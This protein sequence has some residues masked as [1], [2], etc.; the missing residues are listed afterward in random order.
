MI[1]RIQEGHRPT[2]TS[3]VLGA[4]AGYC[5]QFLRTAPPGG[6]QTTEAA[7]PAHPMDPPLLSPHLRKQFAPLKQVNLFLILAP[8]CCSTNPDKAL[9]DSLSGLL[10]IYNNYRV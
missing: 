6:G 2:P 9:S 4:K 1:N 8:I 7:L 10:S 5:T 3:E